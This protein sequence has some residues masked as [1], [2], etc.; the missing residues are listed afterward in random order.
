VHAQAAAPVPA[1]APSM[2]TVP[3]PPAT[4]TPTEP[5]YASLPPKRPRASSLQMHKPAHARH[6]IE[7][8]G[9]PFEREHGVDVRG[10]NMTGGRPFAPAI[11]SIRGS[12]Q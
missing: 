11:A 8:T 7:R 5:P 2:H 3:A 12:C 9:V 1:T 6:R 4:Q 10:S